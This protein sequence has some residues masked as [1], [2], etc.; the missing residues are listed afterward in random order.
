MDGSCIGTPHRTGFSGLIRNYAGYFFSGY[1]G[2]I[3]NTEDILLAE[4]H[5]IYHGLLMVQDM[6]IAEFV[7][8][9]DSLHYIN[10]INGPVAIYHIYAALMQDINDMIIHSNTSIIHTL[11]ESNQCTYFLA[12]LEASSDSDLTTP[13]G[14]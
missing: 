14:L 13:D 9:S 12:K 7:C 2:F 5:A 8:Y 1:Y 11:R 10:I 3:A 6:D 4:L